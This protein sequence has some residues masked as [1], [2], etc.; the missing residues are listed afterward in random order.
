LAL[1]GVAALVLTT[2]SIR[3]STPAKLLS[4][5]GQPAVHSP[6]GQVLIS[7]HGKTFHAPGGCRYLHGKSQLVP[8]EV[9][10]RKGYNPCV[11]CE[12]ELLARS[13]TVNEEVRHR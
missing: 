11:R 12:Q 9:A 6:G 8:A 1:V 2:A 7:E 13:D 3:E 10:V 5:H 4:Q